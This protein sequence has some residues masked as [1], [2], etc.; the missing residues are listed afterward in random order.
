MP[1]LTD[2]VPSGDLARIKN[3][4]LLARTVVEGYCTG[5]HQSPAQG[6]QRRVQ[7]APPVCEGR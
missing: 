3:L 4:Q 7:A 1:K 5:L 6:V 2:I